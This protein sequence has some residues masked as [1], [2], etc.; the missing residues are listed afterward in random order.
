MKNKNRKINK[1]KKEL[2]TYN[3]SENDYISTS[4]GLVLITMIG[5]SQLLDI[6]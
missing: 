2:Y 5:Q 6:F 1:N 4:N 3:L